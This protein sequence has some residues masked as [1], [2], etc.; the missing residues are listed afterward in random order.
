MPVP[1]NQSDN[2]HTPQIFHRLPGQGGDEIFGGYARYLI[3]YL[4]QALKGAIFAT[5][6][7]GK[8]VVTL[9][10]VIS[11]LS[12]LREYQP[13]LQHFWKEGI[14]DDMDARYFRPKIAGIHVIEY[15]LFPEVL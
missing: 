7:E 2:G 3:G 14:F 1:N 15:A 8:H 10:S 13:L 12:I 6:E 4:E 5:Q 11:N 9:E